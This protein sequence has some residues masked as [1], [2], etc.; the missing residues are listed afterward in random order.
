M[1]CVVVTSSSRSQSG[2]DA[3]SQ[4]DWGGDCLNSVPAVG[5]YKKSACGIVC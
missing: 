3:V 5:I 2:A 1:G 4:G